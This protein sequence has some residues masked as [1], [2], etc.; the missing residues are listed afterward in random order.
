MEK[1]D[2][3]LF[4]D[5]FDVKDLDKGGKRFD[6]VSRIDG[7]S[8]THD[9]SL[10]LDINSELYPLDAGD[11]FKLTLASSLSLGDSKE[12]AAAFGKGE[13]NWRAYVNGDE[14]SLADDYDYV[15]YGRVYRYDDASGSKV[16]AF[17]SFGG[18]LMC[19]EGD[20]RHMQNFVVGDTVYLLLR[21]I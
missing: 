14:R 17:V 18:L 19:L 20:V 4:S 5:T 6:R 1:R 12:A 10:I 21:K 11:K 9:M 2:N 13:S 7:R 8:Q 3:I 15:M 16:S